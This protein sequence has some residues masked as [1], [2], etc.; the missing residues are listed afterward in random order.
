M[1]KKAEKVE[2]VNKL[3]DELKSQESWFFIGFAGLKFVE[4]NELR[5]LLRQQGS[6]IRVIKTRLL[7]KSLEKIGNVLPQELL[8][9]PVA[10]LTG[11]DYLAA[12][13]TLQT[14]AKDHPNLV[15]YG[16]YVE[17][18]NIDA[19]KVA[20]FGALPT[21]QELYG[22]LVGTVNAPM[23]RFVNALA[24]PGRGLVSVLRQY[25]QVTSNKQH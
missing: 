9:K 15:I 18:A 7:A 20:V 19:A 24:W 12:A 22:R 3:S 21:R 23:F 1:L 2:L 16:G 11:E 4:F 8:D 6:R 13:K 25:S 17:G 10:L 14:F 5:T